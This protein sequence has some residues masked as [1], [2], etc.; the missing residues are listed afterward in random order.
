MKMKKWLTMI[1]A[2][3]MVI[4][5][6]VLPA[7]A[8]EPVNASGDISEYLWDLSADMEEET[9]ELNRARDFK[10]VTEMLPLFTEESYHNLYVANV[11][12][13]QSKEG[14]KEEFVEALENLD[15]IK[16]VAEGI[17]FLWDAEN[18]PNYGNKEYTE[19]QQDAGKLDG[20]GFIPY[21]IN[22][23]LEDPSQAKGNILMFAG[24]NRT[25]DTE[26]FPTS[27]VMNK[28]GYNCFVVNC[29][30]DPYTTNDA[31][32]DAQRALRMVKYLGEQNG[33][34][35]LDCI[36]MC[37]FS[38]GGSRVINS[39]ENCYI[40][41]TPDQLGADAYVPDAIDAVPADFNT[42]I[43]VYT[44]Y[45][46]MLKETGHW[47]ALLMIAGS[48]DNTGAT[49]RLENYYAYTKDIV[50]SKLIVYEGAGHG[51][52]SG[53]EGSKFTT[54]EA[55]HWPEEADAF[56]QENRGYNQAYKQ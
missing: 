49:Q 5:A 56:L 54:E 31:E 37:G 32:F 24:G 42:A 17:T 3:A 38:A 46:T 50:P 22:Y 13:N 25:N 21:M 2:A 30:R 40:E 15:Q 51:F 35:G 12:V 26:T 28:L 52:G 11:H 29:R 4:S 43:L 27:E 36:A 16:S 55:S 8:E 23:L 41:E 44:G 48:E 33:W 10:I 39:I 19:E 34:G 14:A 7:A 20:Y 6:C 9:F 18:M 1:F 45:D 53:Q 47:P